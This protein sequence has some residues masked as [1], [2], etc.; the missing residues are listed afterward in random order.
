MAYV[1]INGI[2]KWY[3]HKSGK[4]FSNMGKNKA[5]V[6]AV[7]GVDLSIEKGEI[8]GV[9]G[10]SGCGK[11]TLGRMLTRLEDPAAGDVLIDGIS[12]AELIRKDPKQFRRTVQIVFQNPFETFDP[13]HVI[14][15]ILMQPLEIHSIGSSVDERRRI[16]CDGLEKLGITPAE[17]YLSRWPHELSG[18][19]LQ[20]ISVLRSMLLNPL[21]IIADEPVSMLDV[22]VRADLLNTLMNLVHEYNMA[23]VFISH[24]IAVTNYVADRVAVMYLGRIVE[25]GTADQIIK[26]PQHPYT[27]VLISNFPSLDFDKQTKPISI[28]GEPPT[29]INPGPG[30]Y[31]APRCYMATERCFREYP[32]AVEGESGH[33]VCCHCAAN[34]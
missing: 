5:Y 4:L 34:V 18:G 31:F 28:H 3:P 7:D 16:I 9:I 26:N 6:K 21:L 23:M 15:D 33:T 32:S 8:L 13:R 11:S 2:T 20:R 24:D 14:E 27:K 30:C 10:E 29:P 12:T 17:D 22:S 1:E 25:M 19:Q